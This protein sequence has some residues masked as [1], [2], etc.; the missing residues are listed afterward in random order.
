MYPESTRN[1]ESNR[2]LGGVGAL[3]TGIGSL[4]LFSGAVG[5]VGIVGLIL[6]LVSMRGLADDFK[7]YAIYRNALNGFIF[8][9]IGIL[10]A[11]AVFAVFGFLSGFIFAHPIVG[12]LGFLGALGG[13]G[14]MFI[15]VLIGGIFYKQA[16]DG[17]AR[18]SGEGLLRTGS[19]LL[20]IGSI[21]TIILVGFFLLF[22]AWLLIAIGLFSLKPVMQSAQAY[23]PPFTPPT[24]NAETSGQ[25]KYCT[26]CGAENKPE[27][28]F[29]THCGRR[30]TST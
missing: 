18:K 19:L 25:I 26:Y 9:F 16:F 12:A 6:V 17:L 5:I 2:I 22:I 23:I 27:G 24:P 3:L 15:F 10:V 28:T 13:W 21:L 14:L 1:F 4:V 30:L 20:L 29:C 11:I 8:G 7:D